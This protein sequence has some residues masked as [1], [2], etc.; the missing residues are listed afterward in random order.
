MTTIKGYYVSD[1][2]LARMELVSYFREYQV[3]GYIME[4]DDVWVLQAVDVDSN[5]SLLTGV[6]RLPKTFW[7][8]KASAIDYLYEKLDRP[9]GVRSGVQTTRR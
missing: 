6:I 3:A 4:Q 8:T 2:A 9:L 1:E 5:G 7:K